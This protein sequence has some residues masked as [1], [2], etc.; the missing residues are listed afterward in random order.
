MKKNFLLL[1]LNQMLM[2][3]NLLFKKNICLVVA[4]V[5]L[6]CVEHKSEIN[7]QNAFH[8]HSKTLR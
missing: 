6:R 2:R 4:R 3:P 7:T 8:F 5:R 1:P